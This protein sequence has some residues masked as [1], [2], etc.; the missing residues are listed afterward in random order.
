MRVALRELNTLVA[1]AGHDDDRRLAG[2]TGLDRDVAAQRVVDDKVLALTDQGLAVEQVDAV[3][4][5]ISAGAQVDD[6]ARGG[7]VANAVVDGVERG[8][9]GERIVLGAEVEASRCG[10]VDEPDRVLDIERHRAGA[11]QVVA[12][13]GEIAVEAGVGERVGEA[14]GAGEA[15]IGRIG[16]AAVGIERHAAAGG[17]DDAAW[18]RCGSASPRWRRWCW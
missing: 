11:G 18:S 9:R 15:R 5:G 14:V 16:E 6:V 4:L 13:G 1:G 12:G 3:G 17:V 10:I 2:R 8:D 7:V